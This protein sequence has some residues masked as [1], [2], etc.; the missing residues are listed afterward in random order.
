MSIM[1][2]IAF[3]PDYSTPVLEKHVESVFARFLVWL[4][5]EEVNRIAWL[6][7]S[8]MLMT[9]IFFPLTMAS[10]LLHGGSFTLIIGAMISLI[11][12]AIPNMAALPT[13]YTIPAFLIGMLIDIILIIVSFFI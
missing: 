7:I 8:I 5:E 6:G 2:T 9:A 13:K 1:S 12:V 10:I 11:L 3:H 4:K